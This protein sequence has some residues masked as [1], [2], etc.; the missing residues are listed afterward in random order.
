[1]EW[2]HRVRIAHECRSDGAC[3]FRSR[4][5]NMLKDVG[6]KYVH[7]SPYNSKSIGG[8][9]RG[10]RSSKDWLKI[11]KGKKVPQQVLDELT[12]AH[13]LESACL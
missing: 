7:T 10:I 5:S 6:I 12:A 11:D 8:C 13:G 1:M 3:S 9:E 2:A 4:F